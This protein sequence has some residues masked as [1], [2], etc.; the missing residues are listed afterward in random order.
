MTT[1]WKKANGGTLEVRERA[2]KSLPAPPIT[3]T[4][5]PNQS[6]VFEIQV[7]HTPGPILRLRREGDINLHPKSDR[8]VSLL[9]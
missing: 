1:T 5:Y 3:S 7:V 8:G 2:G 4:T 9:I 6:S